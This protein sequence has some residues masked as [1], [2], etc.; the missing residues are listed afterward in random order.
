MNTSGRSNPPQS[1]REL[2][3]LEQNVKMREKTTLRAGWV[4]AGRAALG[5]ALRAQGSALRLEEGNGEIEL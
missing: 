5:L 1:G 2:G 4:S 3:T